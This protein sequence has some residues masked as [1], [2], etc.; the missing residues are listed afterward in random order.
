MSLDF[1]ALVGE[2]VRTPRAAAQRLLNLY[3][4]RDMIWT[5]FWLVVVMSVFFQVLAG[6]V[7]V[8]PPGSDIELPPVRPIA[9]AADATILNA[10]LILGLWKG[11]EAWGGKGSLEQTAT[12]YLYL[13]ALGFAILI[14]VLALIFVLPP[15]AWFVTFFVGI[16][17]IWVNLSFI[18]ELHG[19]GSL[20]K[21]F[22]LFLAV[23]VGILLVQTFIFT[24][25][26]PGV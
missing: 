15:L 11:G 6:M 2:T 4:P 3:P 25:F 12:L 19:Y 16:W 22:A 24:L 8:P 13:Q 9:L 23:W 17:A 20:A 10:L 26:R 14:G 21:S 5:L 7:I 1:R 18:D